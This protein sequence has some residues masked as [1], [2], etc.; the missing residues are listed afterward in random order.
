ME[1]YNETQKLTE[2]SMLKVK[3]LKLTDLVGVQDL[4]Q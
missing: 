3:I 1:K 4:K 2:T